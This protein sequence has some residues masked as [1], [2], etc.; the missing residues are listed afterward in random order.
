[1]LI[2]L[3]NP[4]SAKFLWECSRTKGLFALGFLR[5]QGINISA[6]FHPLEVRLLLQQGDENAFIRGVSRVGYRHLVG[7]CDG[8]A[9][10]NFYFVTRSWHRAGCQNW[11]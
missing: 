4:V 8:D 10:F 9:G 2:S 3:N 5:C 7:H 1:M 11:I 6:I